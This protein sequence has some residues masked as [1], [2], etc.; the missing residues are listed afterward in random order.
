MRSGKQVKQRFGDTAASAVHLWPPLAIAGFLVAGLVAWQYSDRPGYCWLVVFCCLVFVLLFRL[1]AIV[2]VS[3]VCTVTFC[4]RQN[5]RF[6]RFEF[7]RY[8]PEEGLERS[9]GLAVCQNTL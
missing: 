5:W 6:T 1:I 2:G 9:W 7:Y 3:L 4:A 8:C